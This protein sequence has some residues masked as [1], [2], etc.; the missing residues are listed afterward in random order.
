MTTRIGSFLPVDMQFVPAAVLVADCVA[1]LRNAMPARKTEAIDHHKI[2][3]FDNG[4]NTGESYCPYCNSEVAAVD[5]AERMNRDDDE[6]Y[7]FRFSIRKLKCCGTET[8]LD[9]IDFECPTNP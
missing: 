5:W 6:K 8:T 4:G 2:V 9:K 3:F 7:G 1:W